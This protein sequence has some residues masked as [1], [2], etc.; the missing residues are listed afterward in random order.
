MRKSMTMPKSF[1]R[2]TL[3]ATLAGALLATAA[4]GL[5]LVAQD[6]QIAIAAGAYGATRKV[7]VQ[8]NKSMIVDLPAGVA[9]VIVSQPD[10]A[11]AIMRTRTR[12]IIQGVRGGD[13]NILFIDDAGRTIQV[14]DVRVMEEPSQV[15]SALEAALARV[16]PGSHIKVESVTLGGSTN[17]VVLTGSVLS[18]EDKDRAVAVAVQFAGSAENVASI[19]DVSGPQQVMLQVTVSEIRRDVAKQLG[20]NLSG[21]A[22]IGNVSLGFNSPQATGTGWGVDNATGGFPIGNVQL[23]AAIKALETRG[24]VHV[25]AQPT[26]TAM[27][28]NKA[29]FMVGGEISY[30]SGI[31]PTTGIPIYTLRDYGIKLNFTPTVKSNGSIGLTMETEVSEPIANATLSTRKAST[32]I[33]LSPGT[34]LA[35]GGLLDS[36]TSRSIDQLPALGNIPILGALFRSNEY[37]SQE[38]E[39]VIIVTP[40]LASPTPA[41]TV[42]VPTDFSVPATDAEGVFLGA[43]ERRYGV[44]GGG[45]MR[46]GFNGSVGFVLD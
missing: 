2:R 12:A 1:F 14:L 43:L 30:A 5:P 10:L 23:N 40:Y 27:S 26:L 25:L 36:R 37:K 7:E 15:G 32:T 11:A 16:I 42:A 41:N 21:T 20:I 28:G 29:D 33:E 24:A 22:T 31:D 19:I 44:V 17:R 35:I 45:E 38:T 39:L 6:A 9:E 46:G 34:T 13:T 8:L 4:P 18:T 3:G